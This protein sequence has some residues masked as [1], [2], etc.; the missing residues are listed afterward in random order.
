MT[1]S[2]ERMVN[3]IRRDAE[4][5]HNNGGYEIKQWEVKDND[6]GT[7][8]IYLEIGL[9]G[10]EGTMAEYI[11]RDS[12]QIFIGPKGGTKIPCYTRK[13]DGTF[14]NYYAQYKNIWQATIAYG[15]H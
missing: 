7:V 1:K 2:Q 8:S 11:G 13:K 3:R 6:W 14:K 4:T 15:R 10:D 12:L 9:I 5:M